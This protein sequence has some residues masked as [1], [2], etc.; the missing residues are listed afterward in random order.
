MKRLLSS[1][2]VL[3]IAIKCFGLNEDLFSVD[4][5]A[6]EL[7]FAAV[8]QFDQDYLSDSKSINDFYATSMEVAGNLNLVS[9]I[10][11]VNNQSSVLG[12]P[13]SLLSVLLGPAGVVTTANTKNI[14][15][16]AVIVLIC[17]GV[18]LAGA[19]YYWMLNPQ[20]ASN[21]CAQGCAEGIGEVIGRVI[22]EA[23][24]N[25]CASSCESSPQ[26]ALKIIGF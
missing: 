12:V 25:A 10:Q 7:Q 15:A 24:V 13:A 17:G 2:F 16:G 4:Q 23:C 21:A 6:I 9:Q 3:L 8:N 26:M 11:I 22:G 5:S 1:F 18:L 14:D 19:A 20:A